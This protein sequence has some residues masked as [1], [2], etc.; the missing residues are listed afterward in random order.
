MTLE[1]KIYMQIIIFSVWIHYNKTILLIGK[2]C[3]HLHAIFIFILPNQKVVHE[4]LTRWM[5]FRSRKFTKG[6]EELKL[7][8]ELWMM[9]I[10][11]VALVEVVPNKTC[12]T[13]N[14]NISLS[15]H[16]GSCRF[17]S[18]FAILSCVF[19]HKQPKNST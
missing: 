9:I 18:E 6:E 13:S 17:I 10:A 15:N 11:D 16:L 5:E 3:F 7:L 1:D 2:A 19:G 4:H 14:V 12:H 8:H